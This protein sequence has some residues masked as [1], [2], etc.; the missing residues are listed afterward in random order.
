MVHVKKMVYHGAYSFRN[1][2]SIN[3]ISIM[4]E[5]NNHKTDTNEM[6]QRLV[7]IK[8]SRAVLPERANYLSTP[9]HSYRVQVCVYRILLKKY[10][11][12]VN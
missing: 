12:W 11:S 7:Y 3:R 5:F 10:T 4:T 6:L 2:V 1:I 9:K 8:I